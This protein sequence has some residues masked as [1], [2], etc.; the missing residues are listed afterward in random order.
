MEARI[1]A[2]FADLNR[3]A[4]QFQQLYYSERKHMQHLEEQRRSGWQDL[5]GDP[6]DSRLPA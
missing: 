3:D 1:D 6:G 2:L 5:S 4:L